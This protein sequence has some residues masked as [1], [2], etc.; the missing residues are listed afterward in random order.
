MFKDKQMTFEDIE[1]IG[2]EAFTGKNTKRTASRLKKDDEFRPSDILDI[3][4]DGSTDDEIL[5]KFTHG[6]KSK[7]SSPGLH[8]KKTSHVSRSMASDHYFS[9]SPSAA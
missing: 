3:D 9:Q 2:Y 8:K 7:R 6:K 1:K 4:E 5:K